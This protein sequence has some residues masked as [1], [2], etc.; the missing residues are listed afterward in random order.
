MVYAFKKEEVIMPKL[1]GFGFADY[2]A[3]QRLMVS[4]KVENGET[5]TNNFNMLQLQKMLKTDFLRV[6]QT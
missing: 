4:Q 1:R 5:A 3:K 6:H 2:E